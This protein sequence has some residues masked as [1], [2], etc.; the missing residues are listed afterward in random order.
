MCDLDRFSKIQSHMWETPF[1]QIWSHTSHS[2]VVLHIKDHAVL[3]LLAQKYHPK[4]SLKF[5]S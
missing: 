1:L 3:G 5:P 2:T 4:T